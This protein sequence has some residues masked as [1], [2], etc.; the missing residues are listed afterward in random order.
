MDLRIYYSCQCLYGACSHNVCYSY[1]TMCYSICVTHRRATN[2]RA[3]LRK[4]TYE[5]KASYVCYSYRWV[6]IQVWQWISDISIFIWMNQ[7]LFCGNLGLFCGHLGSLLRKSR[8]FLRWSYTL[9][10][11]IGHS[12]IRDIYHWFIWQRISD[13]SICIFIFVSHM[14]YMTRKIL[15][16]DWLIIDVHICIFMS[17]MTHMTRNKSLYLPVAIS[18]S[19]TH[20]RWPHTLHKHRVVSFQYA[21]VMSHTNDLRTTT[22]TCIHICQRIT[23][24][25]WGGYGQ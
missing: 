9:L 15:I 21:W 2:C 17:H 5:D 6:T 23:T 4:M 3:F 19:H 7:W 1:H 13:T 25:V 24:H 10:V 11:Y 18:L 8:F 14:T 16:Y 22:Y 12:W 20:T